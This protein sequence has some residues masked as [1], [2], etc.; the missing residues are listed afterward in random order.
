MTDKPTLSGTALELVQAFHEA[1]T[2]AAEEYNN[3]K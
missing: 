3:N 2:Q 1:A